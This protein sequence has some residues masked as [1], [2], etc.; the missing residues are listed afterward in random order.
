[1]FEDTVISE[2]VREDA[3]LWERSCFSGYSSRTNRPSFVAVKDG[4]VRTSKGNSGFGISHT[5]MDR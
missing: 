4:F 5:H 2:R 1:M 3:E